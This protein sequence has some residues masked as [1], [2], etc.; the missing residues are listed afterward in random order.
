[1][2]KIY[3]L[4]LL[5]LLFAACSKDFLR[6]YEDRIVGTWHIT[7]VDRFGIGGSSRNLA[8][9]SGVFHFYPDG[10]L[11]W[12]DERGQLWQG[13]WKINKRVIAEE[14]VRI[15]QISVVNYTSRELLSETYDNLQFTGTNRFK[16]TLTGYSYQFITYF[17][18]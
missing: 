17:R 16:T 11:E 14:T 15:L 7:D 6:S 2:K 4:F 10:R 18:R 13:N 1:M 9:R 8:F 12:T 5:P 3:F